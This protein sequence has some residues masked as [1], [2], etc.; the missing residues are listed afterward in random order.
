MV[1]FR[2]LNTA[3]S[4]FSDLEPHSISRR[5]LYIST[6]M[7]QILGTQH[8]RL[9]RTWML[10][11]QSSGQPWLQEEHDWWRLNLTAPGQISLMLIHHNRSR[12]ALC[13][14]QT[15][16]G[17]WLESPRQPVKIQT[18]GPPTHRYSDLVDLGAWPRNLHLWDY[19]GYFYACLQTTS[20]QALLD[21]CRN[22]VLNVK[23]VMSTSGLQSGS[24]YF[25]VDS[26]GRIMILQLCSVKGNVHLHLSD[27]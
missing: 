17:W 9:Q 1:F 27:P 3:L 20:F 18:P 23:S 7:I 21:S 24:N 22:N 25:S 15:L 4:P 19:S 11:S 5:P 26:K 14:P 16:Q 10:A 13:C 2:V 8:P 12:S 6:G